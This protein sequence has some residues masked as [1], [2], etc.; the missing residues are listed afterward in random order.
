MTYSVHFRKK[1]LA[2]LE[3]GMSIRA[4]AD[5]YDL[6]PTTIQKW[7]TKLEPKPDCVRK[8]LKIEDQALS[9]DLLNYPDATFTERASR[10]NCSAVAISKAIKRL[11][12]KNR[13]TE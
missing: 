7:K 8:P 2:K 13:S 11:A 10:F 12:A 1:V 3:S 9:D 6:S 5:K 4:L